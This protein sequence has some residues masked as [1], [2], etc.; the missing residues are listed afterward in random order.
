MPSNVEW[1][2][3]IAPAANLVVVSAN[4]FAPADIAAAVQTAAS[5]PGVSV[6]S[7][8]YGVTESFGLFGSPGIGNEYQVDN[9]LT[10]PIGHQPVSFFVSAGD[11]AAYYG[12]SYP[13]I[14]PNAIS[15]GG[16]TLPADSNGNPDRTQETAWYAGGGGVSYTEA[17][18]A[19]QQGV[20]IYG[21]GTQNPVYGLRTNPD[22]SYDSDPYT[23]FPVYS[24]YYLGTS[25]PWTEIGGTSDAA[26]Q[27]AAF[28]AIVN[29]IRAANH[30]P[31]LDGAGQ[32]LPTLYQLANPASASYDP[33]AVQ[34][35][36]IGD[37]GYAAGPG[38]DLVT[39]WGSPNVQY[40][41]AD[42]VGV[43]PVADHTVYWTGAA[44]D[45]YWSDPG[46]WSYSDPL[47][48][49]VV[50]GVLPGAG[51]TVILDLSSQIL[52]F[53]NY[54]AYFQTIAG[55][56]VTGSYDTIYLNGGTLNLAGN[57]T[58][59]TA[60]LG[61][62]D[63]NAS[64]GDYVYFYGGV[65]QNANVTADTNLYVPNY[66]YGY[67]AGGVLDG[68]IEVGYAS[69][70]YML[71][72]WTNDGT[73]VA[74]YGAGL[75]L[76]S[77]WQAGV[78]DPYAGLAQWANYG[79]ITEN[80]GGYVYLG[81][82][83]THD[84]WSLP[85]VL[86]TI[87]ADI[88]THA[89]TGSND[90]V[91][92]TGT[93]DN[94]NATLTI[95]AGGQ[96]GGWFLFDGRIDGGTVDAAQGAL[97]G[98][99]AGGLY[100]FDQSGTIAGILDS[101]TLE[102]T[103]DMTQYGYSPYYYGADNITVLGS[104][105]L[106][107]ATVYLGGTYLPANSYAYEYN[108]YDAQA[109]LNFGMPGGATPTLAGT[110]SIVVG[111]YSYYYYQELLNN[112][113]GTLTVPGSISI[114]TG[115]TLGLGAFYGGSFDF[116][117]GIT[118]SPGYWG[119]YLNPAMDIYANGWVNDGVISMSNYTSA[120][121]ESYFGNS[122]WVNN[123]AIYEGAGSTLT[124]ADNFTNNGVVDV[125][126]PATINLGSPTYGLSPAA[127]AVAYYQWTNPGTI[128]ISP[129]STV[130]VGGVLTTDTLEALYGEFN[131]S[132]DYVQLVGSL[133]N[134][135]MDN[136]VTGG[137]LALNSATGPLYLNGA[138]I[139]QGSVETDNSGDDLVGLAY[140]DNYYDTNN[141]L[142]NVTLH[143]TLDLT[144]YYGADV[145]V[146]N[147]LA[148][149]NGTILLGGSYGYAELYL[150]YYD[151]GNDSV[152]GAG[153]I[154]CGA[155]G[156]SYYTNYIEDYSYGNVTLGPN[157]VVQAGNY[158]T[159]ESYYSESFTNEATINVGY[160]LNVYLYSYYY[161]GNFDNL[162]VIQGG[163]YTTVYSED[164][165]ITN[166][167]TISGG[168]YNGGVN[169]YTDYGS[170]E[171]VG[172]M[173]SAG[174]LYVTN[175]Y[176]AFYG[177]FI[178]NA[179]T[180]QMLGGNNYAQVAGYF[181][182]ITNEG[183]MNGGSD[184]MQVFSVDYGFDYL[185]DVTNTGT[186]VDN[187]P[188]GV[189]NVYGVTNYNAGTLTGGTWTIAGGGNLYLEAAPIAA[190]AATINVSG[191]GNIYSDYGSTRGLLGFNDNTSGGVFNVG[192]G[193]SFTAPSGGFSNA[194]IVAIASGAA[195]STAGTD[196][197]TQSAGS[198]LV[199]GTLTAANVNLGGGSLSGVGTIVGNLHN[200]G[201]TVYAGD[202]P[203]T[204]TVNGNYSQGPG[205]VLDIAAASLSTYSQLAV[206]GS[207]ALGGTLNVSL[208]GGYTPSLG[209]WFPVLTFGSRSGDFATETGLLFSK[210]AFFVA[211]YVGDTLMLVVGPGVAVVAGSNL[212][213]IGGQSTNDQLQI[214]PIGGSTT[215]ATGVQVTATLNR[216][217]TSPKFN[218][219]F[220]TITV[221]GFAGND[222][223]TI[224]PT[225]T[226][227]TNI[228]AG[229]GNDVVTAGNGATSITLGSGND[230]VAAG[231][232]D[233]T[234]TLGNGNNVTAVGNG[235]NVVV[236]GNGNDAIAAG[237]GDN[238]IV[239]GL[240]ACRSRR[241][242]QQHPDRR[243]READPGGRF[244]CEGACRLGAVRGR[245][246]QCRQHPHAPGRHLEQ[247]SPE[248][249]TGG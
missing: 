172:L 22:I 139:Y 73:I 170:I 229:N 36:T 167:G 230:I 3:A 200:S 5:L 164:G 201:G 118:Q 195:F 13:A 133:D 243:Q 64:N 79:S 41:G 140:Y 162:G 232:G 95:P 25:T 75:G 101:V 80:G 18:P 206:T 6:V 70:L 169:V 46:N 187:S 228:S 84:W 37:N 67:I 159:I 126:G 218:Q 28:G 223:I 149:N 234:I 199:N 39:G 7:I 124:L 241:H 88:N 104:L 185:A 105:T 131:L 245:A 190:N 163:S 132:A 83:M 148:L 158:L 214:K 116:R 224:A 85:S 66:N 188:G 239:A 244:T 108:V 52:N 42:L 210:T 189:L 47:S 72:N 55:F 194:G 92:I 175:Y 143:G 82:Y 222:V 99:N 78:T 35:I 1:A 233:N 179:A 58:D 213:V 61:T 136:P 182:S 220:S 207:A 153:T 31:S 123:G 204:L 45:S 208:L 100:N 226:I 157:V 107:N 8:S 128:S 102:G 24:S 27:L 68:Y 30:M 98:Q 16:T 152:T 117:D 177:G 63:V 216:I 184:L 150:G 94:E 62:F 69:S 106:D 225:L 176:G 237:N 77:T 44:G 26:P 180:G 183:T 81:G 173:Q 215:G 197:Y 144:Q 103:L 240:G 125:T 178:D 155:Y 227:S 54:G 141:F 17:E 74:D 246:E 57:P 156:A 171:N 151:F 113:T 146:L 166:K 20:P 15:V 29:Q 11:S 138:Y 145:D 147:T 9:A 43:A 202:A 115:S 90:W 60:A 121:L 196:S 96:S 71:G 181:V 129:G 211:S 86:P 221:I 21:Y 120:T 109:I 65:L 209:N 161:S 87:Y 50:S 198:T 248:R 236:E 174:Y 34:D 93:L 168:G 191:S 48:G 23:G 205:G 186:M 192:N 154:V 76:G 32:F 112:G 38:Y 127:T 122:G 203:G 235:N 247:Q 111:P 19:Y 119:A 40:L 97:I 59:G 212:F 91:W 130:G 4:S 219:A 193:Y 10:T 238:L 231:N 134:S 165:T 14:S 242:R 249:S 53:G 137:V 12:G 160:E 89:P 33:N 56:R 110:G 135:A 114:S 2:H 51:D 217:A 49:P 142:D